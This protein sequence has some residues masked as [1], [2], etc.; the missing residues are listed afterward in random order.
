MS[1]SL[2]AGKGKQH[3]I[4]ENLKYLLYAKYIKT[5]EYIWYIIKEENAPTS[6]HYVVLDSAILFFY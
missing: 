6:W 4:L 5:K 3:P 2:V 1:C